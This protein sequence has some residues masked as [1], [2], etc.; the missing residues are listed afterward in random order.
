MTDEDVD[1][2]IVGAGAT[3]LS[4]AYALQRAGRSVLGFGSRERV[5][6]GSWTDAVAGGDLEIV[7]QWGSPDRDALPALLD[8]LGFEAFARRCEG[9]SVYFGGDG[10]RRTY[11]G[12]KL[13]VSAV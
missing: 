8:E 10:V 6:G 3:G 1:D 4:A 5:G 2:L 9:E 12:E 11:M 13:P 7:V